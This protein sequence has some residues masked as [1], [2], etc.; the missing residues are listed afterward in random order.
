MRGVLAWPAR[1]LHAA[2]DRSTEHAAYAFVADGIAFELVVLP[3]DA[4]RHPPLGGDDRPIERASAAT[5]AQLLR[6]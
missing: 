4:L 2:R 1:T 5:L 3:R 6:G